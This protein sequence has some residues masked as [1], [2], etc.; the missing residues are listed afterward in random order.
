[1]AGFQVRKDVAF[2]DPD[3][4]Q[5][6]QA[7]ASITFSSFENI[8]GTDIRLFCVRCPV[9]RSASS[10]GVE[11]PA[12]DKNSVTLVSRT[13]A[14]LRALEGADDGSD[15]VPLIMFAPRAETSTD[16]SLVRVHAVTRADCV[17]KLEIAL[18]IIAR[19]RNIG[20]GATAPLNSGAQQP[21]GASPRRLTDPEF[22]RALDSLKDFFHGSSVANEDIK[23]LMRARDRG[24][25]DRDAKKS[26]RG[27][28]RSAFRTFMN[29][30]CG[31]YHLGIALLRWGDSSQATLHNLLTELYAHRQQRE[32]IA[33]SNPADMQLADSEKKAA[34]MHARG[35]CRRGAQLRKRVDESRTYYEALSPE[36]QKI[37]CDFDSGKLL[38]EKRAANAAY[39]FGDG[40][41]ERMS[42]SHI[43][44]V[45][46]FA[47]ELRSEAFDR[48]L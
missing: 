46:A 13:S 17:R 29:D 21:A 43:I 31:N 10:S 25:L 16:G 9:E 37:L 32:E 3:P 48:D 11:L 1:M 44:S 5:H 15:A 34:A 47:R 8:A 12:G 23:A 20:M 26:L 19:A 38:R 36:E 6:I 22:E 2:I 42:I 33:D 27:R 14:L 35:Q 41:E 39:G 28:L 40:A 4:T 7:V 18:E 30:L 45:A 24:L